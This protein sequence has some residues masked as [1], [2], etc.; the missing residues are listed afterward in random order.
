M[1]KFTQQSEVR[2]LTFLASSPQQVERIAMLARTFRLVGSPRRCSSE[3]VGSTRESSI[4]SVNTRGD[5]QA[6]NW[7]PHC[8]RC[9][10]T[11]PIAGVHKGPTFVRTR[12]PSVQ[13][14]IPKSFLV[15]NEDFLFTADI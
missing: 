8:F 5:S 10:V 3:L 7:P 1:H 13:E 15:K 9:Y 6:K 11:M 2:V 12:L 4:T 14:N